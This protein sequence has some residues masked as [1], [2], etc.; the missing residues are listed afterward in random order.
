[1]RSV[2]VLALALCMAAC[3]ADVSTI[4]PGAFVPDTKSGGDLPVPTSNE[5]HI[6]GKSFV[7]TKAVVRRDGFYE[8]YYQ[9]QLL[10][11]EATSPCSSFQNKYVEVNVAMANPEAKVVL[12]SQGAFTEMGRYYDYA[13]G[14]NIN[15]QLA[16]GWFQLAKFAEAQGGTITLNINNGTGSDYI[17]GTYPL[18]KCF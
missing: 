7:A 4:S 12:N 3:S 10:P 14:Q 18:Y 15:I 9:I 11:A 13:N 1:M 5:G 16:T 6:D 17:F 2:F 8:G